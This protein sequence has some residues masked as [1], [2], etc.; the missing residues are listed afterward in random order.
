MKTFQK[1]YAVVIT[2]FVAV[3]ACSADSDRREAQLR[4]AAAQEGAPQVQKLVEPGADV[5]AT[6]PNGG[7]AMIEAALGH[8]VEIVQFLLKAGAS[9]QA[10]AC[11]GAALVMAELG[12]HS[13]TADFL[14][15]RNALYVTALGSTPAGATLTSRSC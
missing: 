3:A 1:A 4:A 5:D 8:H 10:K 12:G 6:G 2:K 7:A 15:L 11:G 13:E 9:A 14:T